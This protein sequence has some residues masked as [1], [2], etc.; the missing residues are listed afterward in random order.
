MKK[1]FIAFTLL[2]GLTLLYTNSF[3]F[4][5]N[6]LIIHG[7]GT[8]FLKNDCMLYSGK[9]VQLDAKSITLNFPT[10]ENHMDL[11]S[12]QKPDVP[13]SDHVFVITPNTLF[14][15]KRGKNKIMG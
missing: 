8:A 1:I 5:Q 15:L 11:N 6:L 10:D 4:G 7:S 14:C 9:I 3:S 2:S 12:P 13:Y